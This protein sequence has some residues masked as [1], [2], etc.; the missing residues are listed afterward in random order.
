MMSSSMEHIWSSVGHF[1]SG[2][3]IWDEIEAGLNN[4]LSGIPPRERHKYAGKGL[5]VVAE[6]YV[7][8]E[9]GPRGLEEFI[10]AR[11]R[12]AWRT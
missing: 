7:L 11:E 12:W 1:G 2:Q 8:R 5:S 9:Y 3:Q 6:T 4:F 10:Q